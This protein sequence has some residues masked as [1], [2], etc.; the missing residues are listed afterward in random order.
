MKISKTLLAKMFFGVE[1]MAVV[2][3]IILPIIVVLL[4]VKVGKLWNRLSPK[5]FAIVTGGRN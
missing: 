5:T 3:F 2:T 4:M 1:F